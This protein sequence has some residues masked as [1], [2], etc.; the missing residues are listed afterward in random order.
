MRIEQLRL[1][2]FRNLAAAHLV[3]SEAACIVLQGDNGQGKTNLLEALYMVATGRSF[4]HAAARE[5]LAHGEAAGRIEAVWQRRGVRHQ[6]EV[7]LRA[8]G[9]SLMVDG[10]HLRQ[11]TALL[12]M[13]NMVAF[14]PDDL[15]IAQGSPEHRRRFVDRAAANAVPAFAANAIAYAKALKARN[16][17]LRADG[18][19]DLQQVSAYDAQLVRYGTPLHLARCQVLAALR[20][21]AQAIFAALMP[22]AATLQL[23]LMGGLWAADDGELEGANAGEAVAARFGT[24]LQQ[25]WARDRA[26]RTTSVG[27]HRADLL[28]FLGRADI[29]AFASQGQQR[30]IVL[31]LKLAEVEALQARLGEPPILLLDDVSSE[32]DGRCSRHLFA[33]VERLGCQTW[34]TT[35]GASPLPLQG[36]TQ[37][38]E[39]AKGRWS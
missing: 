16:A 28:A 8:N 7:R 29:R 12:E 10:R 1:Q 4:R 6:V 34:V 26:R 3:P 19:L 23:R 35:T 20:P 9:R 24:S 14:F 21:L 13:L 2:H 25:S 18:R 32:L 30:A 37:R 38:F 5:M 39:V 33:A 31:A 22:A 15:R 11:A 36:A 27:P 17:L